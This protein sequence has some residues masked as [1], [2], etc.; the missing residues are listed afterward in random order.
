M[1]PHS[2]FYC[3][4][5]NNKLNVCFT[6]TTDADGHVANV[7]TKTDATHS[8]SGTSFELTDWSVTQ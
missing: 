2:G 8:D 3:N 1:L 6:S 7:K 5:V 4:T